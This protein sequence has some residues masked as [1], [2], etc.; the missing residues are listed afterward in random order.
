VIWGYPT[1]RGP[2][3]DVGGDV[4]VLPQWQLDPNNK[5]FIDSSPGDFMDGGGVPTAR[6]GK[7]ILPVGHLDAS[8]TL[9]EIANLSA[10]PKLWD[11]FATG[12]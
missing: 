3:V 2:E 5:R 9:E 10:K 7:G 11:P 6:W 12:L 4:G 1:V 8:V